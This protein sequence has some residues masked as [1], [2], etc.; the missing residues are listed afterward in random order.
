MPH[1]K[2][3]ILA[4][5]GTGGHIFP[6]QALARD[7]KD[8]NEE[9]ELLFVGG[10]LSCNRYFQKEQFAFEEVA[11]ATPFRNEAVR[12]LFTIAKGVRESIRH[13]KQFRPDLVIGFG[14]F[15]AFPVLA[16]ALL[17]KIPF[18]LFEPNSIAGKVNR[19]LSRWALFSAVQ[20][21]ETKRDLRGHAHL[22]HLP[23][24]GREK[25]NC[26]REEALAYYGLESNRQTLLIFGGSQGANVINRLF[27]ETALPQDLQLIHITGDKSLVEP[28]IENYRKRGVKACVKQFEDQMQ[29]AW[30]AADLA[31]CR[32]GAATL[33]EMVAFQV[34]GILVPFAQATEDHQS[35]NARIF[36]MK[37]KG[38]IH[39]PEKELSAA[40]LSSLIHNLFDPKQ[41]RI[42]EMKEAIEQF[43]RQDQKQEFSRLILNHFRNL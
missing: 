38:G 43:K 24:W 7:L 21:E 31:L 28:L 4:A 12:S 2:K 16:A 40:K 27:F 1:K 35:V 13:L 19:L 41:N 33:G 26:C 14:S 20:F 18:V 6:A 37:I 15:Y 5:G 39:L 9:V 34:P 23:F 3:I 36:E 17:M 42:Q 29:F 11:C 10:K 22:V 32:A 25:G 8:S 30:R